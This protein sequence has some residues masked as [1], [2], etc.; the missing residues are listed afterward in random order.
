MGL[1]ITAKSLLFA[2]SMIASVGLVAKSCTG[3]MIVRAVAT[4]S[5]TTPTAEA[6]FTSVSLRCKCSMHH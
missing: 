2:Q 3:H 1:C 4:V 6:V 5:S